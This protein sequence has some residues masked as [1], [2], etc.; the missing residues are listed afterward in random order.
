[1][2]PVEIAVYA[3]V[4]GYLAGLFTSDVGGWLAGRRWDRHRQRIR[5]DAHARLAAIIDTNQKRG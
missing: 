3:L 2:H 4:G 1:M 5:Q